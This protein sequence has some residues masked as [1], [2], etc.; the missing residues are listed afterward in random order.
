M[1][2][3]DLARIMIIGLAIFDNDA[4]GCYDCIIV[5]LAMIVAGCLTMP[6][7]AHHLHSSVLKK[8]KYFVKT[9]HRISEKFYR[10]TKNLVLFGSGQG[11]GTSPSVWLIIVVI[12]LSALTAL[13][14]ISMKFM[15]PWKNVLDER[16]VD[17]YIN[18]SAM[19]AVTL[20]WRNHYLLW[21]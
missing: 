14:P 18:N 11:S 16:N 1:L 2:T 21:N 19:D 15:A 4:T 8:M 17:A 10:V 5:S 20:I 13:A 9:K 7:C 12:L 3:Y 6:M